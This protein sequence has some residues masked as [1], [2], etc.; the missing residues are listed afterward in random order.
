MP[1]SMRQIVITAASD[2]HRYRTRSCHQ[3]QMLPVDRDTSP[4]LLYL[5]VCATMAPLGLT[6]S[7]LLSLQDFVPILLAQPR[8]VGHMKLPKGSQ[9]SCR[10]QGKIT[11]QSRSQLKARSSCGGNA[12]LCITCRAT[13]RAKQ[14]GDPQECCTQ[15]H[16]T[17]VTRLELIVWPVDIRARADRLQRSCSLSPV[18]TVV[19]LLTYCSIFAQN[20]TTVLRLTNCMTASHQLLTPS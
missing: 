10:L 1:V 13:P 16:F 8:Q 11:D 3:R 7:H 17:T 2:V 18:H 9:A 20:Q 15:E 4:P 5:H 6:C 12:R 19:L 14:I